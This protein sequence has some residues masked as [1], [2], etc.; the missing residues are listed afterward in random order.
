MIFKIV[1]MILFAS[2]CEAFHQQTNL[3][4][5]K[6]KYGPSKTAIFARTQE[7]SRRHFMEK[8]L[9]V[10]P[11]GLLVPTIALPL[12]ANADVTN[13]V[14]S[15]SALRNVKRS[16]KELEDMELL[17]VENDY[18]GILSA[19]RMPPFSE[20]RKNCSVL[21]KG[22]E[23]NEGDYA[24][25]QSAYKEFITSIEALNNYAG[26]GNRGKKDIQLGGYYKSSVVALNNF[27][28][29]AEKTA[30]VPMLSTAETE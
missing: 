2:V 10:V 6:I 18:S 13:K 9:A 14:A 12:A 21:V 11:V 8:A 25:L 22:S 27:Y 19:I 7:D 30:A 24:S 28:T 15:K 29:L 17:A 23:D 5:N 16:M 26:L 20:V 4:S 3:Y 1:N